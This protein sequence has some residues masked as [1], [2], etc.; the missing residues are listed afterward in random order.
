MYTTGRGGLGNYHPHPAPASIPVPCRHSP[1]PPPLEEPV[2]EFPWPR[3]RDRT[4]R[5]GRGNAPFSSASTTG[6]GGYGNIA[7][8]TTT[9]HQLEWA[10][11]ERERELLDAHIARRIAI[12]S[13][14]RGGYGN[15]S[16]ARSL[17]QQAV[18]EQAARSRSID[19]VAAPV[20]VRFGVPAHILGM[21]R[22]RRRPS[23]S[24]PDREND[25]HW[26][27]SREA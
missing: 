6:R 9:H 8:G 17:Q 22:D 24:P 7:H 13:P 18:T 10:Y 5:R 25:G 3:G 21:R 27:G 16:F 20:G 14:G 26:R 1:Q 11:S 4:Q 2:P 19:P 15:I 12:P 23:R